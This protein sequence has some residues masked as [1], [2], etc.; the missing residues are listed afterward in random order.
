MRK[1][2]M[3]LSVV[4]LFMFAACFTFAEETK[5]ANKMQAVKIGDIK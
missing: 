3:F 4:L 2:I 1:V 5:N